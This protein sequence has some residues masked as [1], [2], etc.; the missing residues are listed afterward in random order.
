MISAQSFLYILLFTSFISCNSSEIFI[1]LFLRTPYCIHISV[2]CFSKIK[3]P[4][5]FPFFLARSRVWVQII[6]VGKVVQFVKDFEPFSFDFPFVS[7]LLRFCTIFCCCWRDN[8]TDAVF[9]VM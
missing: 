8:G 5:S 3:L 9:V 6:V 7:L 4:I 1:V 2:L